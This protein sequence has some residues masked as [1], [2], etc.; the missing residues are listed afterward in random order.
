ML[1]KLHNTVDIALALKDNQSDLEAT[2]PEKIA[3]YSMYI[4]T[5]VITMAMCILSF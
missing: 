1:K 2:T 3:M 4:I 5:S